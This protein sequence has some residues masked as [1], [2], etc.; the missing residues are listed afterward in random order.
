MPE[1][2]IKYCK[3]C[4][5]EAEFSYQSATRKDG[6][7]IPRCSCKKCENQKREERRKRN[8]ITTARKKGYKKYQKKISYMRKNNIDSAR[9]I[10]Q[11]SKASARKKNIPHNLTKEEIED[12]ISNGCCYCEDKEL[13]MTLDRIDNSKGYFPGNVRWATMKEQGANRSTNV[14]VLVGGEKMILSEAANR[15]GISKSTATRWVKTGK[16]QKIEQ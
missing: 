4:G 12:I 10:L 16:I 14:Y 9:W 6:T 11:D 7:P 2:L 1:P 13:R 8:G 5:K 15:L 3:R